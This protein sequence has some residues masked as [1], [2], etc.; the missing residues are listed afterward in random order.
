MAIFIETLDLDA[1]FTA[2][3]SRHDPHACPLRRRATVIR[4]IYELI[5]ID[6]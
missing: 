1:G 2:F 5:Q 3:R 4:K 6:G